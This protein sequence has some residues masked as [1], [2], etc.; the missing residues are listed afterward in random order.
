MYNE[1]TG[2]QQEA[3]PAIWHPADAQ[4][5][6][7]PGAIPQTG[8]DSSDMRPNRHTKFHADR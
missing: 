5:S 3:Y 4:N 2:L 7:I 6:A 8:E 1:Q